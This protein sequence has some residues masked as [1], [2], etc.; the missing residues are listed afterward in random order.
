MTVKSTA[1]STA[2]SARITDMAG[3]GTVVTHMST[4]TIVTAA[5]ERAIDR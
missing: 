1:E 2:R 5:I 3:T 4:N